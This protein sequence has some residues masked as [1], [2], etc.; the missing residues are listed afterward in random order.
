MDSKLRDPLEVPQV[1]RDKLQPVMDGCRRDLKVRV[2]ERM[3]PSQMLFY[4]LAFSA[5]L[6]GAVSLLLEPRFIWLRTPGVL[7]GMAYQGVIVAFAS[8]LAWFW[9]IQVYPVSL[10]SAYTFFSPI[11]GVGLGG[12]LLGE[13]LT[14]KL[15]LGAALVA[16][17]MILV[18]WPANTRG[19]P[20]MPAA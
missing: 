16:G 5:V 2:R 8:Y 14:A 20:A 12:W 17:G 6:L 9:L 13:P 1:P 15:L 3:T 4:Q 11:F 7:G 18:T 19:G 10:V